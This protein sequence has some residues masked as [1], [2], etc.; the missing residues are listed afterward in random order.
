MAFAPRVALAEPPAGEPVQAVPIPAQPA[1]LKAAQQEIAAGDDEAAMRSLSD[2]IAVQPDAA[3]YRLRADVAG[4]LARKYGPG[5]AF[6]ARRADDLERALALTSGPTIDPK[7]MQQIQAAQAD[8]HRAAKQEDRRRRMMPAAMVLGV[9]GGGMTIFTGVL[10]VLANTNVG[11]PPTVRLMNQGYGSLFGVGLALLGTAISL[12][13][14]SRR[15]YRRDQ[16]AR[17]LFEPRYARRFA[18]Q[19]TGGGLVFRF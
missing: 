14:V 2:A 10:L 3:T 16:Q 15:Q 7:H 4:R 1:A 9:F 6:H 5:A 11:H 17:E 12:G 18:P 13:V 8:A 19:L